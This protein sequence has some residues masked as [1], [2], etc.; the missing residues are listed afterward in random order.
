MRPWNKI[1]KVFYTKCARRH[2][3]TNETKQ[4]VSVLRTMCFTLR[5][6]VYVDFVQSDIDFMRFQWFICFNRTTARHTPLCRLRVRFITAILRAKLTF[7]EN[8]APLIII[9]RI[10]KCCFDFIY[11]KMCQFVS[12]FVAFFEMQPQ[13][14][15]RKLCSKYNNNSNQSVGVCVTM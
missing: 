5:N 10:W 15:K 4:S 1:S 7:C 13:S 2:Q 3:D 8:N 11:G 14:F 12:H 6:R 9:T